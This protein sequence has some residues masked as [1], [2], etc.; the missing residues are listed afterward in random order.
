M[1]RFDPVKTARGIIDDEGGDDRRVRVRIARMAAVEGWD[2]DQIEKVQREVR[3][4]QER[5][6]AE[7]WS[8]DAWRNR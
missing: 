5:R 4:E 8:L 7:C 6:L 3:R 2:G 1:T